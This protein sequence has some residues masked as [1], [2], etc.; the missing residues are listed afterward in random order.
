MKIK[1]KI[2]SCDASIKYILE[3]EDGHL[4][5][6]VY[7]PHEEDDAIVM[8][9]SSQIGC[10]NKCTHCATGKVDYVR[11]LSAEEICDEVGTMLE[12]NGNPP[13]LYAVL[14]MGM[15]EPFLNYENVMRGIDLFEQKYSIT[16]EHVT[17]STVG[18]V[19]RIR[20]FADLNRNIRLAVSVHATTD[21][22]RTHIIPLNK[23]FGLPSILDA[24]DYYNTKGKRQ[25]LMQYTLIG[26]VN[27]REIDAQRLAKLAN[28]H[29]CE[30]RLIPFNPSPTIAFSETTEDRI[31]YFCK[32]FAETGV[33]YV[34]SRSRGID[35]SGGCGQLYLKGVSDAAE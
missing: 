27:D 28:E 25:V 22:Q 32:L 34:V 26:D 16:D 10:V 6:C 23:I 15:G 31:E 35:V 33:N 19:H 1:H 11:D 18:I 20:E 3:T 5:E 17:I 4:F 14:F 7:M 13:K 12:D 24:I 30:V 9:L 29:N 2:K 8:C 21:S